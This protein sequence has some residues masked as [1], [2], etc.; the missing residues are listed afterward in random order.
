MQRSCSLF[1]SE[2]ME[3][4]GLNK[5]LEIYNPFSTTVSLDEYSLALYINGSPTPSVSLGLTGNLAPGDTFVVRNPAGTL[6]TEAD[7]DDGTVINFNGDD[8]VALLENEDIVD[9]IG[10]IGV[11]PGAEWISGGVSTRDQTLRR[12]STVCGGDS[13]GTNAFDPS[14]EWDNFLQNTVDG[15]GAHTVMGCDCGDSC[16]E[17]SSIFFGDG[18]AC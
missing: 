2:Y 16:R 6:L 14:V 1:I 3:G 10:Q 15:F 7:L 5:A 9:V 18:K 4:D 12:K 17:G 11:D 13:D 8:A